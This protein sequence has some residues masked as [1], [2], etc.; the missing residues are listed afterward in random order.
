VTAI[1]AGR[2]EQYL[3][4]RGERVQEFW[5]QHFEV[6]RDVLLLLGRGFDPR[7]CIGLNTLLA[8][9]GQ[10]KRDVIGLDFREGPRSPSLN[11]EQL[12]DQNWAAVMAAA[13]GRGQ[14]SIREVEFWSAEGRRISS[15]SARDLF[16]SED[17]FAPYTDVVIDISSMPRSVYFPL[18]ARILYLLDHQSASPK[19]VI[20][21]HV[22][23]AEDPGLDAS[24]KEEGIDEKAEFMASFS[25]GFDEEAVQTPKVW[26]PI[27]GENRGT[28]FDRI[29]DRVKPDEICP[30]LPS[31]S[32]DPRRADD[33][34]IEYHERLFDQHRLDGRGFIYAAEQ[35]PF[36]VYRQLRGALRRYD[37]V[38]GLLGGCRVAVSPLSSKLMSLGALLVAYESK[39]HG[40]GVGIAYIESQGYALTGAPPEA[41]LFGLWLAGECDAD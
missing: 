35:N 11:H 31:P 26:L 39:E 7:M 12:V 2:W 25:G 14:V 38:F 28:Q 33:I 27:L 5:N 41:E 37:D 40:H 17:L 1:H 24:I 30:V 23:V 36:E 22:L 9:E 3:L 20:N 16:D 21:L 29:H 8:A 34:V 32:R 4:L 15:Q 13:N 18:I 19:K 6:A 10:G